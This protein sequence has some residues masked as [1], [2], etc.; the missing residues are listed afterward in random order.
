LAHVAPEAAAGADRCLR[1]GD[2]V[3]CDIEKNELSVELTAEEIAARLAVWSA[4]EARYKTG[5]FAKYVALAR[6]LRGGNQS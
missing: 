3:V 6:R 4:P 2:I 1:D 5:V